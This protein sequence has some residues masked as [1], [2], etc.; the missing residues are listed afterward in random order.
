MLKNM[1]NQFV[2]KFGFGFGF[3]FHYNKISLKIFFV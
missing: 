3:Y 1:K 2:S